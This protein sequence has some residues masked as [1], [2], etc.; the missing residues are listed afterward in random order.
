M[1]WQ[2]IAHSFPSIVR[3]AYYGHAHDERGTTP[4]VVRLDKSVFGNLWS[5]N[6]RQAGI[7]ANQKCAALLDSRPRCNRES[8]A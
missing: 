7:G 2:T 4:L 1:A 8:S 3:Q 5:S 6:C